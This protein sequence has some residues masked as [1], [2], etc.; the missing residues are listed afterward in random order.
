VTPIARFTLLGLA[1]VL[2]P[3]AAAAQ[4]PQRMR[5]E[6]PRVMTRAD[7]QRVR[8]VHNP[9]ARDAEGEEE[10]PESTTNNTNPD[11]LFHRGSSQPPLPPNDPVPA[12]AQATNSFAYRSRLALGFPGPN[13]TSGIR[14]ADCNLAVGPN[15]VIAVVNTTISM[16]AKDSTL[17]YETGL[18]AFF[19]EPTGGG[20]LGCF[21]P[22]VV[23]DPG[24]GRYYV[25]CLNV[26]ASTLQGHFNLAVSASADPTGG[27]YLYHYNNLLDS[28]TID[29][30]ELGFGPRGVYLT[31]NYRGKGTFVGWPAVSKS[32]SS[33]IWVLDKAALLAGG[34]PVRF[35]YDD[36]QGANGSYPQF[37]KTALAYGTPPAGQD[38]FLVTFVADV[39]NIQHEHVYSL[40]L[41][42][43]F[44]NTGPTLAYQ[45]VDTDDPGGPP[46][47]AQKGGSNT[48][49]DSRLGA[50]P[51]C[52][53]YRNGE[54]LTCT[55]GANGSYTKIRVLELDV[56]AWP[57]L[58]VLHK[59]DYLYG[60]A[61]SYWPAVTINDPGDVGLVF[62]R[63]S[64][65][66]YVSGLW[67][68]RMQ[69]ETF[70]DSSVYL[71]PGQTY[72]NPN[73]GT[74]E[75]PF[76]WGDYAGAAVD[77]VDQSLWF[78]NMFAASDGVSWASQIGRVPHAVFVDPTN[79]A[80]QH[81]S[82]T[83]PY[84]SLVFAL[85][86]AIAGSDFVVKANTYPGSYTLTKAMT[87][88][89]DGGTVQFGP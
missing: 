68:D 53:T 4:S 13:E 55:Q 6:P 9:F 57:S 64:T 84:Q 89:A 16:F 24:A 65:T 59:T 79:F 80:A 75:P 7:L 67:T 51:L 47:A 81:G 41:P 46:N 45:W 15:H 32:H 48:I 58:S 5:G 40:S 36:L 10:G 71:Q 54:V 21:D 35:R 26:N 37:F 72:Y 20:W 63:S 43:D 50:V 29:Y 39:N 31:G 27:W 18:D 82:R 44:P 30:P 3:V 70:F 83:Y 87:I 23:Y 11:P 2:A 77:P 66:E 78:F 62:T 76:R 19:S 85:S 74:G 38:E 69:D 86:A 22:K 49:D 56:S 1:L 73:P 88:I 17:D 14:P 25:A 52:A 28:L 8:G 12:G 61:Y 34:S 33:T 42:G 60:Q